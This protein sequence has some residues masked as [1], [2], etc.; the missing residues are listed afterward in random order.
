MLDASGLGD[1]SGLFAPVFADVAGDEQFRSFLHCDGAGT[2]SI[3]AYLHYRETGDPTIFA[4]LAQD[5]LVMNLDDVYCIGKPQSL[6]LA[7]LLARNSIL[8]DDQAIGQI[9]ARYKELNDQLCAMGIPLIMGGGETADCGDVVRTLLVDAVLSGRIAT[10]NLIY[11][12]QIRPGDVIIGLSS[13]GQSSYEQSPNSGIGSNG[14]TLARHAL[15]SQQYVTEYPECCDPG[16]DR[17]IA[18][19]GPYRTTD[20]VEGLSMS[21][22]E[23]LCSPTRTYAPV[24]QKIFDEHPGEIHGVVH[25]TG[26]AHTKVLRFG[27]GNL[28]TK[29]NLFEI[30]TLFSLIQKHGQVDW[31]EMYKVFN[32]GQRLEIYVPQALGPKIIAAAQSFSIDAQQIGRVEEHPDGPEAANRVRL[33]SEV[34]EFEYQLGH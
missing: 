12:S 29:D 25:L 22:G 26:G 7:N 11:A 30:P 3:V 31:E 16:I 13:S 1:S 6:R 20:S 19:Q 23:A 34:G 27:K 18:Y 32:M 21:I 33:E 10:K 17:S 9:I 14:L 5:A 4:G 15:L 24:L 8:I 2:K 28:I